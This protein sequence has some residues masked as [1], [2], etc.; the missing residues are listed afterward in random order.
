MLLKD[1]V[2]LV[3]GST[4]G[5]GTAIATRC[6][7]EGAYVMLHGRNEERAKA[8]SDKL[9]DRAEYVIG[10]LTNTAGLSHLVEK[11]VA[12][13]GA[14]HSLI[15]NAGQS[16]RS[17]IDITTPELFDWVTAL[18]LKA[19]LFLSQAAIRFFRQQ[20]TGGTIV[21]I[22]S[23]N[24]YCGQTDLL[25]YAIT[26]GGLMTMTRN[27]GDA[28]S[29]ENIRVNQLNVGWTLTPNESKI[30][31]GEGFPD[32]WEKAIP[33]HFAPSG[34]L[35]RPE[36]IAAHTVFWASDESAPVTGQVCEVEQYPVIGRNL[37][38]TIPLEVFEQIKEEPL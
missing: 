3:T 10:D 13:F 38:N 15:N 14:I 24:A 8:L 33:K 29:N 18:N 12:Q 23:I 21:N 11:T 19:P 30:K 9:G 32:D 28:L 26:K 37:I 25:A 20:K 27:L 6:I 5:I 16:P 34:K 2:V 4:N 7:A 31:Q 1:N 35:L 36:Q 17:D 22:G